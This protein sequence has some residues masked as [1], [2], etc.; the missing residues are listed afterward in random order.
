[1]TIYLN[2]D[3]LL[4]VR[5]TGFQ[6]GS[7]V[8]MPISA[9]S[10]NGFIADDP[11]GEAIHPSLQKTLEERG[12]GTGDY[13][14]TIEGDDLATHLAL[15]VDTLVYE[16]YVSGTAYRAYRPVRVEASREG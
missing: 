13:H 6:E 14:A 1:M 15:F 9:A 12:A 3:Y 5:L 16:V 11:D 10:I 8:Y 2:N 7:G 4:R